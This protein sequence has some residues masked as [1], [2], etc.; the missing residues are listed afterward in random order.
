MSMDTILRQIL[1]TI[2]QKT[3]S[4]KPLEGAMGG[5]S[6]KMLCSFIYANAEQKMRLMRIMRMLVPLSYMC[7]N[8]GNRIQAIE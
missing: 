2:I 4:K 8:V 1:A 7:Y 3:T 5:Y 6:M